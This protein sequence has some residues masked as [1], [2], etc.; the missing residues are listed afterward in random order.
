MLTLAGLLCLTSAFAGVHWKFGKAN[1]LAAGSDYEQTLTLTSAKQNLELVE[2]ADG[3]GMRT[4]GYSTWMTNSQ[5]SPVWSIGGYFALESFPTDTASYYAVKNS[6][7]G[8]SVG[9]AV[10]KYGNILLVVGKDNDFSY[11]ST[12]GSVKRY[13]WSHIALTIKSGIPV[14][15]VDGKEVFKGPVK[16][17][18]DSSSQDVVICKGFQGNPSARTQM[19]INGIVDELYINETIPDRKSMAQVLSK[20]PVL[21]IPQVRFANDFTRPKY[22]LIPGANWT[23]ET[24][25]LF[26]YNGRYHIFNQK[27]ASNIQLRQIN[28]GHY[29]SPDLVHWT[30]EKVALS[31]D[32]EYDKNGIWSGHAVLDDNGEP[33][34][35]YTA[36]KESH[37]VGIAFASDLGDEHLV[38]WTKYENN[39]V[40]DVKPDQFDRTDMRDQFV[41]KEGD[42]WYMIIGFGIDGSYPHGTLLLYK[43]SDLKNWEFTNLLFEGNPDVDETGRFWEMPAFVKFGDKY[44]LSV[45][46]TPNAGVPARTQ[47]WIGRFENEKF[48]PDDSM[49]KNMEV[50]NGLLSPSF[51]KTPDGKDVTISIIPDKGGNSFQKGWAHLYSLPRVVSLKGDKLVQSPYPGLEALRAGHFHMDEMNVGSG[52]GMPDLGHQYEIKVSFKPGDATQFGLVLYKNPDGSEFTKLYFDTETGKLVFDKEK[53]SVAN[54]TAANV[55]VVAQQPNQRP[56]QSRF[57]DEDSYVLTSTD[58]VVLHVFID[59][60]VVDGF[61][62]EEDAFT[63]RIYPSKENSTMVEIFSNGTDTKA[64]ADMWMISEAIV[65]MN[66]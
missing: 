51:G 24:H 9:V 59:G 30:E 25:S 53:T 5:S 44:F 21:A 46:R 56:A 10:E 50:I 32:H 11:Y 17:N 64:T 1:P 16:V 36:G 8:E 48:I 39:P 62:N 12:R 43:S 15:S 38:E 66:Y 22:H 45:N 28:W 37:G 42:S 27:N 33:V 40:I 7:T 14:V 41:W 29:S 3:L 58:E 31:P 34:L 61:I 52:I 60:S 18:L 49:P 65:Q 19:C 13:H 47:Y 26:Y 20:T 55:R 54:S 35:I 63:N 23:N 57:I 2:G 4:D 6:S